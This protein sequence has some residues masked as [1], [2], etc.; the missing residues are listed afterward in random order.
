MKDLRLLGSMIKKLS[1]EQNVKLEDVLGWNRDQVA[2]V[3]DGRL[4]P[5]FSELEQLSS[6]FKV[7]VD[8][9]LRGDEVYYSQDFVHCMGSFEKPQNREMILDIIDDYI[10]LQSAIS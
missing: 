8:D 10:T 6:I 7:S 5:S 3:F 9:L 1:K 2:A 4:F